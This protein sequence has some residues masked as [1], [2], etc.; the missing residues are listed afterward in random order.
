MN[1]TIEWEKTLMA[2]DGPQAPGQAYA[3]RKTLISLR[4]TPRVT[5]PGQFESITGPHKH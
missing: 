2:D 3:R 5:S 1:G 4:P